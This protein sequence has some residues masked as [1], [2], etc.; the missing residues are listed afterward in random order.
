MTDRVRTD[1][2]DITGVDTQHVD[3]HGIPRQPIEIGPIPTQTSWVEASGCDVGEDAHDSPR[4]FVHTTDDI[5]ITPE[6]GLVGR[7][8]DV[9]IRVVAPHDS[10]KCE[11]RI[12]GG[13]IL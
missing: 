4:L 3:Q 1:G 2:F 8:L 6:D 5:L 13:A 10:R 9:Q 11:S 7:I 12:G